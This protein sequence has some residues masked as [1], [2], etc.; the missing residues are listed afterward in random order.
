MSAMEVDNPVTAFNGRNSNSTH[1]SPTNTTVQF[2][3]VTE[4]K[5][6]SVPSASQGPIGMES[7]RPKHKSRRRARIPLKIN[8]SGEGSTNGEAGSPTL[9]NLQQ[10]GKPLSPSK[11]KKLADKDRHSRTGRRGMPK[12]G[13]Y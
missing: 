12:K 3:A 4:V 6:Y 9:L 7:Q 10:G 5:S 13:T 8:M 11:M 1:T 2:N